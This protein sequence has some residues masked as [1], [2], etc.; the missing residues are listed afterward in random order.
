VFMD[1]LSKGTE[2]SHDPEN[3]VHLSYLVTYGGL[4]SSRYSKINEQRGWNAMLR[5]YRI[6][7]RQMKLHSFR[8][9]RSSEDWWIDLLYIKAFIALSSI[10]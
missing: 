4:G 5:P 10:A 3:S 2:N 1:S 9:T 7:Q 8:A 6:A